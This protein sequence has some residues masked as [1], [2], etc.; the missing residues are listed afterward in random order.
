MKKI[1]VYCWNSVCEPMTIRAMKESGYQVLTFHEKMNDY[2]ADAGF[3]QKFIAFLHKEKSDMVFSFDYF[4]LISMICQMNHIPYAA[5]IYDCPQ[6][7][8]LSKTITNDCNHIFCFDEN[9]A[10]RL[11]QLGAQSVY[12]FPLAADVE[13]YG[14]AVH[15]MEAGMSSDAGKILESAGNGVEKYTCDISFVGSLYNDEKNRLLSTEL[16]DFTAGYV[17]GLMR[18]QAKIYGYNLVADSLLETVADEI[19]DKC[20]LMLGDAYLFDPVQMAADAINMEV[21]SCDRQDT[22]AVLAERFDVTLYSNSRLPKILAGNPRLKSRGTVDYHTQMPLVFHN[23]RINL[24]ITSRT[25]ETGVPQRVFDI[26]ACGGFCLTNYQKEIAELFEDGKE[27]VMYTS[28][29]DL[30]QKAGYYLDH[31]AER[32][33]IASAGYEKVKE[34]FDIKMRIQELVNSIDV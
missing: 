24:N 27:L 34:Y 15:Q 21:T 9:Y 18:S 13:M 31:E 12:H 30:L 19:V 26:L 33:A 29:E 22:L 20:G 16:S 10:M 1:L 7:T 8:L 17:E 25:I 2:H 3:A 5:W 11:Q 28:L 6:Y 4:P 23:S 14:N 32:T